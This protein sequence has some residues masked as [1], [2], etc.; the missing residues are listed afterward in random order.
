MLYADKTHNSL[1]RR[2]RRPRSQGRT[3]ENLRER[4]IP[5]NWRRHTASPARIE[6]VLLDISAAHQRR[7]TLLDTVRRAARLSCLFP[8]TVGRWHS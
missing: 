6:I 7:A 3:F 2:G 8:F 4:A 5:R 1:P